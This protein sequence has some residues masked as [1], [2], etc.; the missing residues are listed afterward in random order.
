MSSLTP[1]DIVDY[2]ALGPS[3]YG[4]LSFGY[5]PVTPANSTNP[6]ALFN[7]VDDAYIGFA[8]PIGPTDLFYAWMRIDVD[9]VNGTLVIEDWAYEDVAGVGIEVGDTGSQPVLGDLD[10]D[11]DVDGADFM[12]FQRG[13]GTTFNAIDLADWQFNYGTGVVAA[14]AAVPE[15]GTLGLLAAGACGLGYL[16]RR[17]VERAKR[18]HEDRT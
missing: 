8:F 3:F 4:V 17:R 5:D 16:R 6:N 2:G 18:L 13:F 11:F 12:A 15:P 14:S 7:N 9:N 10:G 1:G